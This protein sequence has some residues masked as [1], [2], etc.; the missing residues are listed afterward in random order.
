MSNSFTTPWTVARQAPL[1]MGFP[2]QEYWNGLPFPSP[3]D[4]PYWR[5]EPH[6]LHWQA[7]SLPLS[8]QGSPRT[9]LMLVCSPFSFPNCILSCCPFSTVRVLQGNVT[10]SP[11]SGLSLAG[12]K[13]I[14]NSCN[15]VWFRQVS[16]D[17]P[18]A[19]RLFRNEPEGQCETMGLQLL[20]KECPQC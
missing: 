10:S 1:P 2:R 15:S 6:L 7:D 3:G 14:W 18:L 19:I 5:I 9:L 20:K 16:C 4:L 17:I 13:W 12:V 8:Y 11:A